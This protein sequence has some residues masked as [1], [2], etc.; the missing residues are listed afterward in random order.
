M[1]KKTLHEFLDEASEVSSALHSVADLVVS[2]A[3]PNSDM[4][5]VNPDRLCTLLRLLVLRL[6]L[7]LEGAFA[8]A[9]AGK[10]DLRVV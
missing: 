1:N 8:S 4:H 3:G 7:A 5:G 6:D 2:N 9:S 10:R